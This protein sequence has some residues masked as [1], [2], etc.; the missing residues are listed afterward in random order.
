M[1]KKDSKFEFLHIVLFELKTACKI[2][3]GQL[4]KIAA[5]QV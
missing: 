5:V 1:G 4:N 3:S 2:V